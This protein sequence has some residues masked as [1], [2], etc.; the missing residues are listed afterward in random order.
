MSNKYIFTFLYNICTNVQIMN[1]FEN[2]QVYLNILRSLDNNKY[3][4]SQREISQDL[5][6]SLGKVNYCLKHLQ[7]KGLLK[8]ENFKKNPNKINYIYVLTPKG[9][10]EKANLTI[11]FMKRK[12]KK[13]D[14]LKREYDLIEKKKLLS[15][16]NR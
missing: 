14:E 7:E 16:K 12:M 8:I 15:K 13:Y 4:L 11:N 10:L 5:G 9:I 3:H 2:N 1:K 6:I